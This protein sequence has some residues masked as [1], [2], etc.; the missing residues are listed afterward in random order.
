MIIIN[1]LHV[2]TDAST[3]QN[4]RYAGIAFIIVDY[5]HHK[6]LYKQG[7]TIQSKS[8]NRSELIAVIEAVRYI[9]TNYMYIKKVVIFSD[10]KWTVNCLTGFWTPRKHLELFDEYES[11]V[12]NSNT[13]FCI[14]WIKGHNG[15]IYN[16]E[17]DNLAKLYRR[18]L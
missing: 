9:T 14:T 11:L 15:N 5:K 3:S 13:N 6:I 2:Y 10:N 7:K 1:K 4:S 12:S 16:I 17:A 18:N 8:N